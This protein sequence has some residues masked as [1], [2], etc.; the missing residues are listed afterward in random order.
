MD[1]V[2]ALEACGF[3]LTE[4]GPKM[5]RYDTTPLQVMIKFSYRNG[6]WTVRHESL[7]GY[8]RAMSIGLV[9]AIM[10]RLKELDAT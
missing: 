9:S 2:K 3:T 7:G 5:E 1:G 10:E 4:S 6:E 8:P